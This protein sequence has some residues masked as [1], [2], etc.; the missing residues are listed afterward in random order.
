M[1][2]Y[3]EQ[4]EYDAVGNFKLLIHQAANGNWTRATPTTKPA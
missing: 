3:T 2:D 4:Y 1:R